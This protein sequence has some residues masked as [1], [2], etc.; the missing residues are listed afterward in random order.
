M[1]NVGSG[2]GVDM[3]RKLKQM[4]N[5]GQNAMQKTLQVNMQTV[6]TRRAHLSCIAHFASCYSAQ[7]RCWPSPLLPG[8]CVLFDVAY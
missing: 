2:N 6:G 1:Q 3:G 7:L 5:M 8:K 4:T